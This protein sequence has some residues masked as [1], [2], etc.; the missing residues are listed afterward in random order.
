MNTKQ[1]PA[2]GQPAEDNRLDCK[3]RYD[4]DRQA[5]RQEMAKDVAAFANANGGELF[6]GM[7][8]RAGLVTAHVGLDQAQAAEC[9]R[10]FEEAVRD[11]VRPTPVMLAELLPV[12]GNKFLVHV[13]VQPFPG[14][15]VG[16]RTSSED[17]T[18][19]VFPVRVGTQTAW[20]SPEQLVL[21]M[22]VAHRR[23]A[24]L[25]F[26]AAGQPCSIHGKSGFIC[27]AEVVSVNPMENAFGLHVAETKEPIFLSIDVVN[28]VWKTRNVWCVRLQGKVRVCG[29][30]QSGVPA[31]A[32]YV[33]TEDP[34]S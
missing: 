19:W 17:G 1:P 33:E 24:Q 31:V 10:D 32:I 9:K 14:Q 7:A 18:G 22:D 8:E 26:Q 3:V 27:A 6:V 5:R 30:R 28:T 15:A 25:L 23:K 12:E 16:V 13:E 20:Y 4:G 11:N 34:V 29:A 2:V 21:L